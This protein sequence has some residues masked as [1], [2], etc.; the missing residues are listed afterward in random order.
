VDAARGIGLPDECPLAEPGEDDIGTGKGRGDEPSRGVDMVSE[1]LGELLLAR[2]HV[3]K[4]LG[5]RKFS[6]RGWAPDISRSGLLMRRGASQ[7]DYG[8]YC[9]D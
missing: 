9:I 3:D 4:N 1:M 5:I 7:Y 8:L 2:E 6:S